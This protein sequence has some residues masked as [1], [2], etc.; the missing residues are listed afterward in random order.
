MESDRFIL[1]SFLGPYDDTRLILFVS[2]RRIKVIRGYAM[3][4]CVPAAYSPL[5]HVQQKDTE[6]L[7]SM[8]G[9]TEGAPSADVWPS[10]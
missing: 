8:I 7:K 3:E 9:C 10:A 5:P 2:L 6:T 4:T 1:F